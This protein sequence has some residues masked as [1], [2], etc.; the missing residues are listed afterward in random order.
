MDVAWALG[1]HAA[2]VD[3]LCA[4]VNL[5]ERKLESSEPEGREVTTWEASS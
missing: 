3:P 2:A 5:L 4:A 1:T